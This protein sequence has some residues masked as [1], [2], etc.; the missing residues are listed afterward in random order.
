M[1]LPRRP[2]DQ[3]QLAKLVVDMA[4]GEVPNDKEQ[5]LAA[6]SEQAQPTGRAKSAKARAASQ[7]SERR[8]EVARRAA[9]VRWG[10]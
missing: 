8:A 3:A 1:P 4:T 5:V 6:F 2:S 10:T 7:T 9:E